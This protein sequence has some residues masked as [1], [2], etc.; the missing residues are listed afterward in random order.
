[1]SKLE[2]AFTID[3]VGKKK[4]KSIQLHKIAIHIT[5][6]MRCNNHILSSLGR[7]R[8]GVGGEQ[9]QLPGEKD[10]RWTSVVLEL[11]IV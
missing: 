11:D 5:K 9:E 6:K 10:L 4:K 1:M 8:R 3:L 2:F 7:R